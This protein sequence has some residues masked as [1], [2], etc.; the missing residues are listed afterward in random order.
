MSW[1]NLLG[2]VTKII[3]HFYIDFT[4]RFFKQIWLFPYAYGF[5]NPVW[6][7]GM[8]RNMI[9]YHSKSVHSVWCVWSSADLIKKC[10]TSLT[11]HW[12]L[13][14]VRYNQGVTIKHSS[15]HIPEFI[16]SDDDPLVISWATEFRLSGVY[17]LQGDLRHPTDKNYLIKLNLRF[18]WWWMLSLQYFWGVT[19]CRFVQVFWGVTLCSFVQVFWRNTLPWCS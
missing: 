3:V 9:W 8:K 6:I 1:S 5:C 10:E 19:L 16:N 2:P 15:R 18:P 7:H 14:Y 4:F 13:L 11:T 17:M 12:M